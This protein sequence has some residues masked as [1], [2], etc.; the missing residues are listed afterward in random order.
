MENADYERLRRVMQ[1]KQI[2][3]FAEFSRLLGLPT[4]QNFTDLK[5]GKYKITRKFASKI[6][7]IF[8]D[9]S[10]AWLMTG[11]GGMIVGDV[12][13]NRG[14]VAQNVGDIGTFNAE[15]NSFAAIIES[16]Q[17]TIRDQA[18]TIKQLTLLLAKK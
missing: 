13:N 2:P 5:R 17:A 11:E 1:I 12:S 6:H 14:I 7:D 18:E 15:S 8:P 16:Q 4:P 9:I 3:S 10:V